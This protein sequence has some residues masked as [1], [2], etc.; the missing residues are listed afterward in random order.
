MTDKARRKQIRDELRL[1]ARVEFEASLPMSRDK[2]K[3][4][5]DYLDKALGKEKCNDDHTLT[6]WFLEL[7]GIEDVGNTIG[8]I[9]DNG[10]YCNCELLANVEEV[11]E[12]HS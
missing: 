12:Q 8:W 1:E 5:F 11:L 7:V 10:G 6:I 2:F 9:I 3:G 4:L